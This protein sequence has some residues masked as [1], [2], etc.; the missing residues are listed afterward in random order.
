M[1]FNVLVSALFLYLARQNLK[2]MKKD[3]LRIEKFTISKLDNL[4]YIRG[5]NPG[6]DGTETRNE[7]KPPPPP[8]P[9]CEGLFSFFNIMF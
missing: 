9:P 2:I 5:G 4:P 7:D 1:N 6:D 3:K 8:P